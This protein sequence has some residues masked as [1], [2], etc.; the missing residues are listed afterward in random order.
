MARDFSR[1]RFLSG[2]AQTAAGLAV[3]GGM[4]GLLTACGGSSNGGGGSTSGE[5][6]GRTS[7][8]PRRGG[9]LKV[10]VNS[11]FNSFAP[12]TG[13]FDANGLMYA[14]TVFDAL[15]FIDANG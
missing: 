11:D 5:V 6:S 2:S 7:K 1:R 14:A 4:G 13:Q 10:G 8:T 9:V 12:P 15:M 3:V